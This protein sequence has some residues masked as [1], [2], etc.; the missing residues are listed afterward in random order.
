[1]LRDR[2]SRHV[3][4]RRDLARREL[5]VA[6]ESQDPTPAR[7]GDRFERCFHGEVVKHKLT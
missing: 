2:R 1:M 7:L 4:V 6:D 3:E 5:V